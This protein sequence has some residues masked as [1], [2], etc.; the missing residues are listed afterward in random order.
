MKSLKFI[1]YG[2]ILISVVAGALV[3][4]CSEYQGNPHSIGIGV[5]AFFATLFIYNMQR[6]LRLDEIAI[7]KS[8]R[9]H[10][11]AKHSETII[12]F[13]V[14]GWLGSVLT[15][16]FWLQW[17]IDFWFLAVSAI[18]GILYAFKIHPKIAAI[19]DIPFLKIYLIAIQWA[20]VTVYWPY[21]RIQDQIELP[22]EN[23]ISVFFFILAITIPFDIRDLI[24]DDKEKC[25]IPQLLGIKGA[26][27]VAVIAFLISASMLVLEDKS[28]LSINWFY[29]TYS[30]AILLVIFSTV[31][32]HEL[33]YSGIIDGWIFAYV[34]LIYLLIH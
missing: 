18:L 10:W 14:I 32:R 30:G 4:V 21:I 8:D 26:K 24:Y 9:H 31:K 12:V 29:I 19:R 3:A 17:D 33:F 16:F 2:N 6:V 7:Q 23:L 13:S 25:T 11:L 22:I 20:L 28:V 34:L 1:I 15:Y 5:T 27:T